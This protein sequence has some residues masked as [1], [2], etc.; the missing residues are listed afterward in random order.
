M[1]NANGSTDDE[2]IL[3]QKEIVSQFKFILQPKK[4][5]MKEKSRFELGRVIVFVL[6][7]STL[8]VNIQ[9]QRSKNSDITVYSSSLDGDRLTKKTDITF[10]S[11]KESSLP[12][13]KIDEGS[14]FQ[15]IDGF[16]ATFNE[17]GMICLNSLAPEAK[18]SVLKMLFEPVS[19]AGYNLMKS[20]I[21][22]CD[23]A[24]AGPWYTYNDTPGD[25]AMNHFSIERDLGPNGLVTFIKEAS[26]FG[27]IEI[28]S[29]MDF[30]PDWMYYSLKKGEKHIKPEYYYSL[31]KYYS[32]YIQAY[33]DNGITV[34]Y[35][36]LFNEAD[37]S[38]YSNVTYKTMGLMIKNYVV[39]RLKADGLST[40]IQL[41]ET[42]NR[43]E[44]LQKFPDVLNDP[45]VRKHIHSLT[46]HG[47]DWDKFSSLTEMHNKY[48]DLP[49]WQTEVCYARVGG[50]PT[51]EPPDRPLPLPVFEFSDG[52]F[53][54]NMIMNDMKNWVSAWIYWN[55]I[56]D[57][58]GGPWLISD[59]HGDPD[60]NRQ[61]PVVIIDRN[62]KKV[63]YTGLYY[64][65]AHF[66]KFIKPGA[67]RINCTGGIP[68]LNFAAFQNVDGSIIL[69]VINNGDES[70][71]KIAWNNKMTI[72]RLKAHSITTIKWNNPE[73]NDINK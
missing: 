35:L 14:R 17:A 64:Y 42:S 8:I 54:G 41:G 47:Y 60:D 22:A 62:T 53:W 24:S 34:N 68:Q 40:K 19:G 27:K 30:A 31:A 70:D 59:I 63:T 72:S 44:A 43:P 16:G 28:E 48:P 18:D 7:T 11:D 58:D 45:E 61:Q 2:E 4:R 67:Y 20:P 49:I 66:S 51:N 52:E 69:N 10:T 39:P 13:I 33:A 6:I 9:C 50:L 23:F 36:N 57:Q 25:T 15:K 32:K 29:P 55:M 56:L 37:N 21:A 12:V 71:C 26:R 46:V 65:L 3:M 38:W 5:I 73:T 1:N